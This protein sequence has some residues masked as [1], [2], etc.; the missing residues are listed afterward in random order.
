MAKK[1][2]M[3]TPDEHNAIIE[4]DRLWWEQMVGVYESQ[5]DEEKYWPEDQ[6]EPSDYYKRIEL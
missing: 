1:K 5:S 2:K 6:Q 4:A 3:L